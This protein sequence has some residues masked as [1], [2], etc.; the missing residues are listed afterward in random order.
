[1]ARVVG[2][3]DVAVG[4]GHYDVGRAEAEEGLDAR[5]R[6]FQEGGRGRVGGAAVDIEDD[7]ADGRGVRPF[8]ELRASVGR[9]HPAGEAIDAG[10]LDAGS[11]GLEAADEGDELV[12][13]NVIL[14]ASG[15]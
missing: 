11:G 10:G 13:A 2:R 7:L 1:M 9:E 12:H 14:C 4:G 6:G 5:Q 3:Q 15:G 8:V